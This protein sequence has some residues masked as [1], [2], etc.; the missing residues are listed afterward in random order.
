M[1]VLRQSPETQ[2]R[3]TLHLYQSELRLTQLIISLSV[4]RQDTGTFYASVREGGSAL[5]INM[6]NFSRHMC[7]LVRTNPSAADFR[8]PIACLVFGWLMCG[9][10]PPAWTQERQQNSGDVLTL[11]KAVAIALENNRPLRTASLEVARASEKTAAAGTARLPALNLFGAT[12]SLLTTTHFQFN[13]GSLGTLPGV[14][15]VPSQSTSIDQPARWS[16]FLF[17]T[18]AQPVT[19]LFRIT[20]GI[21]LSEVTQEVIQEQRRDQRHIAVN[22]V[23]RAYFA[24]L[25]RQS[26][27]EATEEAV[28]FLQELDR[29]VTEQVAQRKAL[30]SDSLEVKTRLAETEHRAVTLDSALA[31]EKERLNDLLGRDIHEEF[32]LTPVFAPPRQTRETEAVLAQA[33]ANRPSVKAARLTVQQAQHD[34][35]VKKLQYVPDVSLVAAHVQAFNIGQ[36]LP[37]QISFAGAFL[38]WE[39]FDWGRKE[40][41]LAEKQHAIEQTR[42]GVLEA[43]AQVEVEIRHQLR[44][45]QD[46]QSLLPVK[47]LGQESSKEKLRVVMNRYTQKSAVLQDVLKAQSDLADANHQYQQAL[48]DFMTA[49]TDLE[50]AIGLE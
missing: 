24:A 14:G 18:V 10:M 42:L 9:T 28:R 38:S 49:T 35:N 50:R 37:D 3:N 15:P 45:V 48:L 5:D 17:A 1:P 44:N 36:V 31:T 23:K 2:A 7:S 30:R 46:A 8:M 33:L 12:G 32:R 40:R 21:H 19:Q 20:E 39:V 43:E 11:E 47:Q 16:T 27:L 29:V 25:H 26:A 34:R 4:G 41:E 13:Q 22:Q 6:N